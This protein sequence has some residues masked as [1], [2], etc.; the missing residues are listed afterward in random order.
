MKYTSSALDVAGVVA[1]R[2]P[3][4]NQPITVVDLQLGLG[5]AAD[6][7][8]ALDRLL[9]GLEVSA[10]TRHSVACPRSVSQLL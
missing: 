9:L 6:F 4:R 3:L 5:I 8:G 10:R 2:V 1:V 7:A